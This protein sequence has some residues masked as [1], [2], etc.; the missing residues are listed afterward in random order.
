MEIQSLISDGALLLFSFAGLAATAVAIVR[1][2]A[3]Q[4]AQLDDLGFE[5]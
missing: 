4:R 2:A 5:S 1:D 3:A